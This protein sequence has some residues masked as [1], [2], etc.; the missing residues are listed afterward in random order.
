M[1]KI[2]RYLIPI[3]TVVL[4][5][6]IIYNYILMESIAKK[7]NIIEISLSDND[8]EQAYQIEALYN[9][10]NAAVGIEKTT[11]EILAAKKIQDVQ[12]L[13]Q[14]GNYRDQNSVMWS[15]FLPGS[16]DFA[17]L[18]DDG[19]LKI[20]DGSTYDIL[21]RLDHQDEN[22]SS[23]SFIHENAFV[24]GTDKGNIYYW[25]INNMN[26]ELMTHVGD[27]PIEVID[28]ARHTV[29]PTSSEGP[30]IVWEGGSE[31]KNAGVFDL[32]N[33]SMLSMFYVD[34]DYMKDAEIS[35]NG[36]QIFL[37]NYDGAC[38][39]D[40]RTGDTIRNYKYID[41]KQ[42]SAVALSNDEGLL[43]VGYQDGMVIIWDVKENIAQWKSDKDA[44]TVVCLK[45]APEDRYLACGKN[46]G[47][48]LVYDVIKGVEIGSVVTKDT[49]SYISSVDISY[50]AKFLLISCGTSVG[51]YEM[52]SK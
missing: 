23:I 7:L 6:F 21:H 5:V 41:H 26:K 29:S 36:T 50:D 18:C 27:F 19:G 47:I 49:D 42:G 43:A 38:L 30:L 52:P 32:R 3:L 24:T 48:V 17:V 10:F 13:L 44:N 34:L 15:R 9:Y 16:D 12:S 31:E 35:D 25:Y 46:K 33:K 37:P 40:A 45:F 14:V 8:N 11:K 2:K 4:F 22:V 1:Y 20:V 39:V 51:I 28:S